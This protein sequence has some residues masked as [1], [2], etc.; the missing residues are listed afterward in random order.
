MN[1]NPEKGPRT[2]SCEAW[3]AMLADALDGTLDARDAE[4]F[5]AHSKGCAAGC[6][7]L[8]EEAK[9]GTEWLRFLRETPEAPEGLLEK[10]LVG[11]SGLPDTP[12]LATSGGMAIPH[13]PWLGA[14]VGLLQRHVAE[15]RILMTLAM[16]FFSIALTLNLT[17]VRLNQL[18]LSDLSPSALAAS[19]SHQYFTTWGHLNHY[20]MNLRIV[21]ELE[22]RVNEMRGGSNNSAPAA[23]PANQQPQQPQ[24]QQPQPQQKPQ[25]KSSGKPGGSA[26]KGGSVTP[27]EQGQRSY[28][29]P[30]PVLAKLEQ[31]LKFE[32]EWSPRLDAGFDP[33][34]EADHGY[35]YRHNGSVMYPVFFSP[36]SSFLSVRPG[37][38][39][40]AFFLLPRLA[41]IRSAWPFLTEGPH[42]PSLDDLHLQEK[43]FK[44]SE[45]SL[46]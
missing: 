42:E 15:S 35:N 14:S 44:P 10:I 32:S 3:E 5:D 13:Q 24:P 11:T 1:H 2:L 7:E 31:H 43:C 28:A 4:A 23:Q 17:G 40:K 36:S 19:V 26:R 25:P 9:R 34:V 22:S 41:E 8:L 33:G 37:N 18:K 30:V 46:V 29:P 12:A 16:A 21:Y 20:Y 39:H 27:A 45:R 6:A 38:H